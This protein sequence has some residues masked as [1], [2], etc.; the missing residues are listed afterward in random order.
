MTA[1]DLNSVAVVMPCYNGMPYLPQALRS[2][3]GQTHQPAAIIVVDDGSLDGS[4]AMVRELAQRHPG[5]GLRL[6]QQANAGEP[7]ARNAGIRAALDGSIAPRPGW[8]AMLDSDDWWEPAKLELQL[9]AARAA[10]PD[11]VLVHT[12]VVGELPD[13]TMSAANAALTSRR[14][15]RCLPALLGPG[16]IGHPSILVRSDALTQIGGYD[17]SFKQ[18]CDIDL[19]L[20]LSTVGAFAF[21]PQA[22]LHY[23]YHAGQMSAGRIE[24]LNW[25]FRAVRGFF[26]QHP[27]LAEQLGARRIAENLA[28]LAGA[29]VQSAY[30]RRELAEFRGLLRLAREQGVDSP[31][32]GRWR[33]RALAPDWLIHLKDKVVPARR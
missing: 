24:Q 11:C 4:A 29:K 26:A 2:A 14:V 31:A 28:E 15:G 10:G 5:R 13:G 16:S 32:L 7:A 9:Q 1:Y 21:V 23:R 19:Y 18:A 20:R 12:A 17:A 8:I 27:D 3:L 22:L 30:W 6:L 25:H 33:R